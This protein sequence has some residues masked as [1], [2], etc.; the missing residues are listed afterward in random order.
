MARARPSAAATIDAP[1]DVVW[2]VMLDTAAYGDW[3]PFVHRVDC[4]SAPVVGVPVRL[5]VRWANGRTACS[6]ERIT[7][8]EPPHVAD[9]VASALLSYAYE[10]VPH[11][12]G[13]VH[14]VRHQRLTQ[15]PDGPTV[16]ETVQELTGP[17][18]RLAGPERITDGFQRHAAGLRT[19]AEA[20]AQS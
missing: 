13:L 17:L 2:A 9:G 7:A 15:E 14:S 8:V 20:L 1:I 10:G 18:V 19:R 5:H 12:L 6:P 16:Y 4:D 11:R 3:N